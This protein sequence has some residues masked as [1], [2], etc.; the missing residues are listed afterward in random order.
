MQSF[1]Q[2]NQSRFSLHKLLSSQLSQLCFALDVY[3]SLEWE[4]GTSTSLNTPHYRDW[5]NEEFV[6]R[7][8]QTF[9]REGAGTAKHFASCVEPLINDDGRFCGRGYVSPGF[10]ARIPIRATDGFARTNPGYVIGTGDLFEGVVEER[11]VIASRRLG[12]LTATPTAWKK[13]ASRQLEHLTR[14][15]SNLSGEELYFAACRLA[16]L[17]VD[18]S[19]IAHCYLVDRYAP[20]ADCIDILRTRGQIAFLAKRQF[21][22]VEEDARASRELAAIGD[23]CRSVKDGDGELVHS[24]QFI[25]SRSFQLSF[26]DFSDDLEDTQSN[27]VLAYFLK[28]LNK[29]GLSY[30]VSFKARLPIGEYS[31]YS[32][33]SIKDG[34][35]LYCS[36][37][38]VALLDG[39][40][41]Q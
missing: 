22:F 13:W 35:T 41:S 16:E 31:G 38:L 33:N 15:R 1:A 4:D 25:Q 5:T 26:E 20:I 2:A 39:K 29:Q 23:F 27:N 30:A 7:L 11:P 8:D 17:G 6:V 32:T 37:V 12:E 10:S 36:A 34:D 24:L 14:E 21:S 28:L 19:S 18:V 3:V 9:G 40:A